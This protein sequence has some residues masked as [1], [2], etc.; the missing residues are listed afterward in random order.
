M[1]DARRSLHVSLALSVV[2]FFTLAISA[3]EP[4][5]SLVRS[6][7]TSDGTTTNALGRLAQILLLSLLPAA[8]AFAALPLL[9]KGPDGARTI[10]PLNLLV[11][12][13]LAASIM[14][15]VGPV[16]ADQLPCWQGGV[17]CG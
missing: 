3:I 9:R 2:F 15:F 8:F 4:F 10:Y 16:V 12:A 11:A 14:V 5:N 6:A 17:D 13:V 7:L 1:S